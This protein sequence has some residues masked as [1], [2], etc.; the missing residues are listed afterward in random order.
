VA[1]LDLLSIQPSIQ[2]TKHQDYIRIRQER[3][4]LQ[5]NG[6]RRINVVG[7][8]RDDARLGRQGRRHYDLGRRRGDA[9][10]GRQGLR[11]QD[12]Q[13]GRRRDNARLGRQGWRHH[14][15]GL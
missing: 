9:Q 8:R 11:H 4:R 3:Q 12:L 10:V 6:L 7:R 1:Q 2:T 14:D 15:L 5:L 13:Q